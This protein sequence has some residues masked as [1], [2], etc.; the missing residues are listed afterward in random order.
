MFVFVQRESGET[1]VTRSTPLPKVPP[2]A[3]RAELL[4]HLL[5]Y[6]GKMCF[7]RH[8]SF[9]FLNCYKPVFS[10]GAVQHVSRQ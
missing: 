9:V 10:P 5:S 2:G 6:T 1:Y 8:I 7:I 3:G 4:L